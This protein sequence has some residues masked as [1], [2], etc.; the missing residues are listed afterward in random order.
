M[1]K[2]FTMS[3][4]SSEV[5]HET[6]TVG[7]GMRAFAL[8]IHA[9]DKAVTTLAD[10][11]GSGTMSEKL[12]F[13]WLACGVELASKMPQADNDAQLAFIAGAATRAPR[14]VVSFTI[15]TI[16][17]AY[18]QNLAGPVDADGE[19]EFDEDF[20]RG[21]I[22]SLMRK[23]ARKIDDFEDDFAVMDGNGANVGKV[24]LNLY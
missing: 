10:G 15:D 17:G 18:F 5:R 16:D 19:P 12:A 11:D 9:G 2:G 21:A 3:N 24:T 23:A 22:S 13:Y 14:P 4:D 20:V 7:P 8:G 1:P 6:I